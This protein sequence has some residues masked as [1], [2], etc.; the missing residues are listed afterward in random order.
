MYMVPFWWRFGLSVALSYFENDKITLRLFFLSAVSF[1]IEL[2]PL[3]AAPTTVH[4]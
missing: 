3:T 2:V 1:Y 4:L